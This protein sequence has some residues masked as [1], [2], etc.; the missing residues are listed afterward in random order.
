ME[1]SNLQS[2]LLQA[3]KV[4]QAVQDKEK[5]LLL[6]KESLNE[7]TMEISNLQSKFLQTSK[8]EDKN[9][10]VSSSYTLVIEELKEAISD[11][12]GEIATLRQTLLQKDI[13]IQKN[14]ASINQE[15]E[16]NVFL[17]KDVREK[18]KLLDEANSK[19]SSLVASI[20]SVEEITRKL[21]A[22]IQQKDAEILQLHRASLEKQA[23][24]MDASLNQFQQNYQ[25]MFEELSAVKNLLQK[26]DFEL[27]VA[28]SEIEV[29][30]ANILSLEEKLSNLQ[31]EYYSLHEKSQLINSENAL[32]K[33]KL[34]FSKSVEQQ[35]Q[36]A[37]SSTVSREVYESLRG[38]YEILSD[39]NLK[40]FN[41]CESFR[42]KFEIAT[43][44]N[45]NLRNTLEES[46]VKSIRLSEELLLKEKNVKSFREELLQMQKRLS[47]VNE[48]KHQSISVLTQTEP[49]DSVDVIKLRVGNSNQTDIVENIMEMKTELEERRR[50]TSTLFQ[51]LK[52]FENKITFSEAQ[53]IVSENQPN[54]IPVGAVVRND[55]DDFKK[56]YNYETLHDISDELESI[57]DFELEEFRI[58]NPSSILDFF[59][60]FDNQFLGIVKSCMNVDMIFKKQLN[61]NKSDELV[62]NSDISSSFNSYFRRQKHLLH[63][64]QRLLSYLK[65][66]IL[67]G[68]KEIERVKSKPLNEKEKASRST[69]NLL[70]TEMNFIIRF[71]RNFQEF[72]S[73]RDDMVSKLSRAASVQNPR[74]E[75]HSLSNS[76]VELKSI[77]SDCHNVKL[78]LMQE[79]Q[80][81]TEQ[82]NDFH[83]NR[84]S[85]TQ[86]NEYNSNPQANKPKATIHNARKG[87]TDSSNYLQHYETRQR[88]SLEEFDK[89]KRFFFY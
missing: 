55:V 26:K 8:A 88:H 71:T 80:K 63:N 73:R 23:I 76:I 17:M 87:L 43:M 9:F 31:K 16:Q 81:L 58:W 85:V 35:L 83:E 1:I 4:D 45:S 77:L 14:V 39:K 62:L 27:L 86:K 66:F 51:L 41:Q 89:H 50:E 56:Q 25:S 49:V 69:V 42:Q 48:R 3:A 57:V 2:K 75:P 54:H 61:R 64:L 84:V 24:G 32:L 70:T 21:N 11:K 74:I 47:D 15:V 67:K 13:E 22:Q 46:Q 59:E 60:G 53:K 7:K 20:K 12:V 33:E 6:L 28:K 52:K 68:R 38:E 10:D 37:A 72:L 44:E 18:E 30:K 82:L 78:Q 79:H 29:S 19:I 65:A 36:N 5:E 34:E 40:M